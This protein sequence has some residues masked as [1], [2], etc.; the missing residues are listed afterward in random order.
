MIVSVSDVRES[1][2]YTM[3]NE[4]ISSL[5]L[6]ARAADTFTMQLLK[7][8]DLSSFDKILIFCGPGNNGGDGL[9]TAQ[10][11][12]LQG[13]QVEVVLAVGNSN[14]SAEFEENWAKLKQLQAQKQNLTC[15]HFED[16][17][18]VPPYPTTHLLVIDALFGIGL[19]R[20]LSDYFADVVFYINNLRSIER[21]MQLYKT[22]IVALDIP[23]GLFADKHTSLQSPCVFANVTY[24]FQWMKWAFLLP[25]N[26]DRVGDVSV[27]DIGLQLPPEKIIYSLLI[28]NELVNKLYI[29]PRKF[30]HKGSNGH[31]LLIAGSER[32]PG[33]AVLSA[34]AAMRGGIGKL[35][36]HT[37]DAVANILPISLPEAILDR[38]ANLSSVSQINFDTMPALQA[39]AVGPGIGTSQR[40]ESLLK[41]LM[42]E[43]H[44]PLILDADA[45]NILANHKTWL[46]YL[47]A[48]SILTPHFKELERLMGPVKDDFERIEKVRN[49]AN[50]YNVIVVV[51]GAHSLVV[52][53]NGKIFVNTTGNPGMATAGSGDVLTG[54][55]LACMS[56]G[57]S[58]EVAAILGVYLHG[59]AGD[60]ALENESEESLI[61]GDICKYL[62]N[63]F[64]TMR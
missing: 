25:E 56:K 21:T 5:N 31:G 9:V 18:D 23:S 46:A 10:L 59:K 64:K 13:W 57:Y 61:A 42:T 8:V 11:L 3:K 27:L 12:A 4:P 20:P 32:M 33:A 43:V 36:V 17:K 41:D 16:I 22:L 58:P 34:T 19:S 2:Q 14:K 44:S 37:V 48:F 30:A 6:M 45:L 28:D 39:I 35:T 15:V 54:I 29:P 51:K 53:P 40:T 62:G 47:P 24:T 1:E 52:L 55:L 63:A 7:E 49:F 38:D 60:C 50:K 26:A